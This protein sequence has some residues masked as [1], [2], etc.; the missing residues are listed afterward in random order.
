MTSC[1]LYLEYLRYKNWCAQQIVDPDKPIV[2]I[3][4]TYFLQSWRSLGYPNRSVRLVT[5]A[6]LTN[7]RSS[8]MLKPDA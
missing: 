8:Y 6:E 1:E 2:P 7:V 5:F 4:Y 3:G